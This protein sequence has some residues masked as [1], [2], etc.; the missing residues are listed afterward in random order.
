MPD[1]VK[2]SKGRILVDQ[3]TGTGAPSGRWSEAN[4]TTTI[5]GWTRESGQVRGSAGAS[6]KRLVNYS[7][8]IPRMFIQATLRFT[9]GTPQGGLF[10]CYDFSSQVRGYY[11]NLLPATNQIQIAVR[12]ESSTSLTQLSIASKTLVADTDYPV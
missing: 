5:S 10:G 7:A 2:I 3:F 12:G 9:G 1:F 8:L 11:L 6:E 4:G